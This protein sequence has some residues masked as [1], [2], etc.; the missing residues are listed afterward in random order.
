MNLMFH[1]SVK[2]QRRSS[3]EYSGLPCKTSTDSV[4][5]NASFASTASVALDTD[6]DD[7]DNTPPMQDNDDIAEISREFPTAGS[8]NR[9]AKFDIQWDKVK[10]AD[11]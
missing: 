6:G 10:F 5:M 4:V 3:S 2:F 7:L 11:G 1:P 8:G 9:G